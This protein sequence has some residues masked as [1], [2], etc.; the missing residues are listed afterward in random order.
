LG[1][2]RKESFFRKEINTRD[3]KTATIIEGIATMGR[4]GVFWPPFLQ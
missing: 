3:A 4:K 1:F 2:F